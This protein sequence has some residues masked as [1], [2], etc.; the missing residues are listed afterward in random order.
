[1]EFGVNSRLDELQAA[2]LRA[3]L[4]RL[5]AATARRR[6][7][8]QRYRSALEGGPVRVPQECDKG[9]VYHLFPVLTPRRDDLVDALA[10]QGIG[11][12]VHYPF[13]I[14]R[15]PAFAATAAGAT[16]PVAERVSAEVCSLPLYPHLTDEACDRVSI[17]VR[18]WQSSAT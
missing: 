15:Q 4:E 8:A 11:T 14:H 12:L 1:V 17:A 10:A 18:E 9:H 7:L 13:S 2:V 5:P 6:A 3:R 16:C